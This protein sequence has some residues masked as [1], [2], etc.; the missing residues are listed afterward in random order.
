M[1]NKYVSKIHNFIKKQDGQFVTGDVVSVVFPKRK[2][3]TG[4]DVR[5]LKR[6]L[7]QHPDL[8][9]VEDEVWDTKE[10]IFRGALFRVILDPFELALRA[11]IPGQ[12]IIPYLSSFLG[13]GD[14]KFWDGEGKLLDEAY[15]KFS[16]EEVYPFFFLLPIDMWDS[17]NED[18]DKSIVDFDMNTVDVPLYDLSTV[19]PDDAEEGASLVIEAISSNKGEYRVRY[20]SA[21]ETGHELLQASI[22]DASLEKEM[23]KIMQQQKFAI[24]SP[25]ILF[26]R[27]LASL[28]TDLKRVPGHSISDLVIA[29]KLFALHRSSTGLVSIGLEGMASESDWEPMNGF[30]EDVDGVFESLDD[31]F[32]DFELSLSRVELESLAYGAIFLDWDNE[33]LLKHLLPERVMS[34]LYPEEL[35]TVD[36]EITKL[37]L[38]VRR[39]ISKK[40]WSEEKQ[41]FICEIT[42]FYFGNIDTLRKIDEAQISLEKG[43]EQSL[44]DNAE[45]TWLLMSMLWLLVDDETSSVP[46]EIEQLMD[47]AST[48]NNSLRE[49]LADYLSASLQ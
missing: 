24:M 29:S 1:I 4:A 9:Q 26:F 2:K 13:H 28:G 38:K 22:L 10:R 35:K 44:I 21:E 49:V 47:M 27:A 42:L 46:S 41:R 7:Q 37:F 23:Q 43:L 5:T 6:W 25:D 34:L 14:C 45:I 40:E 15:K 30:E 48:S 16:F 3:V 18:F 31:I 39:N 32:S 8:I 11:F 12:R 33:E 20:V 19:L 36:E 17:A